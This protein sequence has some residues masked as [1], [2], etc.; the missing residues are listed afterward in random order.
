VDPDER[1]IFRVGEGVPEGAETEAGEIELPETVTLGEPTEVDVGG[2]TVEVTYE[3]ADTARVELT[4]T[5]ETVASIDAESVTAA[6]VALGGFAQVGV[7]LGDG[8]DSTVEITGAA[9]ADVITGS[10]DDVIS[11]DAMAGESGDGSIFVDA[12]FG[13]DWVSIGGGAPG[14]QVEGGAGDDVL[15]GGDGDDVLIGGA[16]N[17][18]VDGGAGYDAAR[19]AGSYGEYRFTYGSAG[20]LVVTGPDDQVDTLTGVERLAFD[21]GEVEVDS[22]GAPPVI[23]FATLPAGN[24]DEPIALDISVMVP[25]AMKSLA[26]VEIAG[27]PEGAILSAGALLE[28]GT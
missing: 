1:V 20:E 24:E 19:F 15:I 16:G 9:E 22:I 8:G 18:Q 3:D 25:N 10:G 5:W 11:I 26:S 2:D 28:G 4:S 14:A 7:A 17:D 12:G 27:I 23:E 13:D 21:D 6:E